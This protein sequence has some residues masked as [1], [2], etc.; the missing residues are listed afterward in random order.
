MSELSEQEYI[1]IVGEIFDG[2]TEFEFKNEPVYLKHFSIRDQRYIHRFYNKFKSLAMRKGIPTEKEML[3]QLKADDLWSI[4]EEDKI[5]SLEVELD[6]LRQTQKTLDL[7]SQKNKVQV[8]I[9]KLLSELGVL[10]IRR[11]EVV[12]RTAE[13][14]A[15]Q[16][17]NEEFIRYILFKDQDLKVHAFTD[18]EFSDLTDVEV[19]FLVESNDSCSKRLNETNIQHAVLRSFFSMYIGQTENISDFYGKPIIDCSAFQLKLAIYARIFTNIFQYHDDIPERI[20]KDPDAIFRFSEQK[21]GKSSSSSS[22]NDSDHNAKAIFGAEKEDLEFV[23]PDAKQV[24]L[25]DEIAKHGGSMNME[26][27]MKMMGQ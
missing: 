3:D 15:A 17:S 23:D 18:E 5:A 25:H 22:R 21:R 8:S 19:S 20:K 1:S 4:E 10:R 6:N 9:D 13:D 27:L 14:F 7:P 11:K 26:Q 24:S 16:R 12:G 2:Y